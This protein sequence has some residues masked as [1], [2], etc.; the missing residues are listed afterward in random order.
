MLFALLDEHSPVPSRTSS[1][2]LNHEVDTQGSH[3]DWRRLHHGARDCT[4]IVAGHG[5]FAN[6]L[7]GG[8][9]LCWAFGTSPT[10]CAALSAPLKPLQVFTLTSSVTLESSNLTPYYEQLPTATCAQTSCTLTYSVQVT[11]PP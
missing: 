2:E 3:L 10:P 11:A 9:G 4:G 1:G 7:A 5:T 6:V 8:Y